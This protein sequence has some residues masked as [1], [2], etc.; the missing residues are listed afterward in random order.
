MVGLDGEYRRCGREWFGVK[1]RLRQLVNNVEEG[2][3]NVVGMGN[4]LGLV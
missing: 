1:Y 3:I 2:A 4:K